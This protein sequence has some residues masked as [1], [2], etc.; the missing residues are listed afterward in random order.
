[1]LYTAK[2]LMFLSGVFMALGNLCLR[3]N[4][5]HYGSKEAYIL[6]QTF[7]SA[8]IFVMA[9]VYSFEIMPNFSL[10]DISIATICGTLLA[11]L[12]IMLGKML[13]SGP[14]GLSLAFLNASSIVPG[15]ILYLVY[16]ESFNFTYT[17][18]NGFGSILVI[19]GLFLA[20][21]KINTNTINAKWL[22]YCLTAF[23]IHVLFLTLFQVRNLMLFN[24]QAGLISLIPYKIPIESQ[25][26]FQP[27]MYA[28]VCIIHFI[29]V[30]K[31]TI[32]VK[33]TD[34]RFGLIGGT[35]NCISMF[36]LL[37]AVSKATNFDN[38]M[39]FPIYSVTI[40]LICNIW[41]YLIYRE[42]IPI[43]ANTLC[44]IGLFLGAA[45]INVLVS[46]FF[47]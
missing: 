46:A 23:A 40:V 33:T 31:N 9:T 28:T 29:I 44:L 38:A 35:L 26:W 11:S 3:K 27:W 4:F 43:L 24:E 6:I 10:V 34:I 14:P 1:M 13:E 21:G 12:F 41:A 17:I 47:S 37:Q 25:H 39:I 22:T 32:F 19:I 45:D 36:L 30:R 15:L 16:G 7:V 18:A 2:P 42:Q 5:D 8:I 20:C